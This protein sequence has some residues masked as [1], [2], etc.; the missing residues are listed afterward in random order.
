MLFRSTALDRRML[1]VVI[2]SPDCDLDELVLECPELTWNQ[3]FLELDRLSR[4][5]RIALKQK[6]PGQ[7]RVVPSAEATEQVA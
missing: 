4:E 5:G 7:Y 3:V 2:R 6:A 1:E